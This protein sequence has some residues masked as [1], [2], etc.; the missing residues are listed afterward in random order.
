M[1]WDSG[2]EA[3]PAAFFAYIAAWTMNFSISCTTALL[4]SILV[5]QARPPDAAQ[6]P[7]AA[8]HFNLVAKTVAVQVR[9]PSAALPRPTCGEQRTC[10]IVVAFAINLPSPPAPGRSSSPSNHR[11]KRGR[12]ASLVQSGRTRKRAARHP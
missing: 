2:Y 11:S 8:Q 5:T 10:R 12:A 6:V 4:P 1:T 3:N 7:N 9:S